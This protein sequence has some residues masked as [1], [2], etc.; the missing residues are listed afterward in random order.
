MNGAREVEFGLCDMEYEG[1]HHDVSFGEISS[2]FAM[3]DQSIWQMSSPMHQW[4][5]IWLTK[6]SLDELTMQELKQ[7][8]LQL[9]D[10]SHMQCMCS[11]GSE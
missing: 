10:V 2:M 9:E 5:R 8:T 6:N 4:A 7:S 1:E 11:G 3:L